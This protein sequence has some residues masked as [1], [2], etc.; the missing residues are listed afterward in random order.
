MSQTCA[1]AA[2]TTALSDAPTTAGNR[3]TSHRHVAACCVSLQCGQHEA[4]LAAGEQC[5]TA[6]RC[7]YNV[8]FITRKPVSGMN[9]SSHMACRRAALSCTHVARQLLGSQTCSPGRAPRSGACAAA[10]SA[11][12]S[13]SQCAGLIQTAGCTAMPASMSC[14]W[15]PSRPGGAH[16]REDSRLLS[17]ADSAMLQPAHVVYLLAGVRPASSRMHSATTH[18]G[19]YELV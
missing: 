11:Q 13:T 6:A 7:S 4:V 16:I 2:A 18:H 12:S 19:N 17:V 10:R 1:C 3:A 5:C 8:M 9:P 15:P 14:G